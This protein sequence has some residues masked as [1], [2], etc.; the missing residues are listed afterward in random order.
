MGAY[1]RQTER[2]YEDKL[3]RRER[4]VALAHEAHR[5]FHGVYCAAQIRRLWGL[6]WRRSTAL[7]SGQELMRQAVPL[8]PRPSEVQQ[9]ALAH[10]VGSEGR[11]HDFDRAFA[12]LQA[13]TRERWQRIAIAWMNGDSLEPVRLIQLG[14]R[15]LVRDGHHRVSVARAFRAASIEAVVE[16]WFAL[17]APLAEACEPA[18]V[19]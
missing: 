2:Y 17:P 14:D 11:S 5:L 6:L 1:H 13:H 3:R 9:V 15:Y 7:P 18:T 19:L 10:V 8:A 12:P 4:T 16:Q